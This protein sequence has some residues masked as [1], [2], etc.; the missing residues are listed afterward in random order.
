MI[1]FDAHE[2]YS[3]LLE[4]LHN[5]NFIWTL[6][7]DDNRAEDGKALR[8]R[9]IDQTDYLDYDILISR[10]C[11]VLEMMIAFAERIDVDIMDN[12]YSIS[13]WFWLMIEKLE[14]NACIN[15]DFDVDYVEKVLNS[16]MNR[17][18]CTNKSGIKT[19][20][21]CQLFGK[22]YH[23]GEEL[24]FQMQAFINENYGF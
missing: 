11:S 17:K 22:N 10:P 6:Q 14:L 7:G 4:Y 13:Y 1:D 23:I 16:W 20:Y 21:I 9:F 18:K 19:G 5:T 12:A 15:G 24:W 8:N 2:N 3:Q